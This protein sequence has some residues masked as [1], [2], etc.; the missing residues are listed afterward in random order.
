VSVRATTSSARMLLPGL[1]VIGIGVVVALAINVAVDALSPAKL[2]FILAGFALLIPTMFLEDPKAYW[3]FLLVSSIPFDISKY[4]SASLVDPLTLVAN[5]GQPASGTVAIE[6]YVTDVLLIAMLLPWLARICMKRERLYFPKIGYFFILYLA[7]SVL[8]SLTNSDSLYLSLFE[9]CRQSLYFLSFV[10]IINNV[11]T[12]AQFRCVAWAVL[13]GLII[14][15]TSVIVFFEFNVGTENSIFASLHDQTADSSQNQTHKP[16]GNTG[17]ENLTLH[18]AEHRFGSSNPGGAD[19][20]RSQGMF[21]HPAIA[22]GMFE[23]T[24]P[25]VLA[26]LMTRRNN[27]DRF[28]FFMIFVWGLTAL[29]LTFSRAGLIGFMAGT[30]VLFVLGG[31]SGLISRRALGLAAVALLGAA[32]LSVPFLLYYFEA[33]PGSFLM[34]FYLFEAALQGY[35]QHPFFGVG[36]NNATAAMKAGRQALIAV[37]IPMPPTESAD[38]FYLVTLTEAGPLGFALFFAFFGGAVLVAIRAMREVAPDL[39]PLLLGIP[40]GLASLA[41]QN[42]ADDN[43]AGHSISATLWLFAALIIAIARQ[44]RAENQP[45]GRLGVVLRAPSI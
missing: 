5:Y 10:Y 42:I 29:L 2:V 4:L 43:L 31:R 26:Y 18:G 37:G 36:L 39:K 45:S 28:L 16:S 1:G 32:A 15:A 21:K 38:S 35:A 34:R 22:A 19:L 11:R 9:L 44:V 25:I 24:L 40:A 20:V 3:L 41:I 12:D 8:G 6:V 7:W 33:R 30:L 14:S 13:L 27:R 23:L 17:N